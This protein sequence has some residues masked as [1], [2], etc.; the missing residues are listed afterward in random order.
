MAYGCIVLTNSEPAVIQTNGVA[1]WFKTKEEL[2]SLMR[3]YKENP[4]VLKQK[5]EEGYEFVRKYRTNS[6]AYEMLIQ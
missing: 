6:Y 1:V 4:E 5:Q 3:Y 2:E